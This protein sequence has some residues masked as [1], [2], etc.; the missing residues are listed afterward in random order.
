MFKK[1]AFIIISSLSI[2]SLLAIPAAANT[3]TNCTSLSFDGD[4][5]Y[6][7][8]FIN[9]DG[10]VG[11]YNYVDQPVSIVFTWMAS[12]QKVIDLYYPWGF[13]VYIANTMYNRIT[14]NGVSYPD[15]DSGR[16]TQLGDANSYHYR[17]YGANGS[18]THNNIWGDYVITTT[19]WDW[20]DYP[21]YGFGW[22]EDVE[23]T[24]CYEAT[25]SG[26]WVFADTINM[27]NRDPYRRDGNQVWL[28]DGWASEIELP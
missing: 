22:S 12:K 21:G 25:N 17:S 13:T 18:Y 15:N 3:N 4:A 10:Y 7:Y 2:I 5:I 1:I 26:K 23:D 20:T 9:G 16:K 14:D 24:M 8:D 6:N 27:Q 11:Y 28:S 19:H